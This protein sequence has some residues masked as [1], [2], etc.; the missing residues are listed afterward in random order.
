MLSKNDI[1]IIKSLQNKKYRRTYGLFTV[2]GEKNVVE[3]MQAKWKIQQ[4]IVSERFAQKYRSLVA[5]YTSQVE[6]VS[7]TQLSE[8]G[9]L[10]SNHS[11]LAVVP[12]T[13]HDKGQPDKKQSLLVLCNVQDPGNLGTIIRTADWFGIHQIVCSPAT[14]EWFNPKVIQATMGA[15][16]RVKVFYVELEPFL[17]EVRQPVVAADLEG[18]NIYEY[19]FSDP[20]VILMGS[21]SHG[22]PEE[23]SP[24]ITDRLTI[25]AFGATESLNVAIATGIFCYA[26]RK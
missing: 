24:Y 19:K 21:E 4:L 8:L 6:I 26:L 14:V 17:K 20:S 3:L 7:E 13:D 23:L 5:S 15:F 25:P 2:E 1:K 22:I 12:M 9:H 16:I 11:A 10:E 18:R